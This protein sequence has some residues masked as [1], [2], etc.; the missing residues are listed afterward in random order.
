MNWFTNIKKESPLE[1]S[2]DL[3]QQILED[4]KDKI[5]IIDTPRIT[6]GSISGEVV[7]E[8]SSH[9]YYSYNFDNDCPT[10]LKTFYLSQDEIHH[11]LDIEDIS[12][13]RKSEICMQVPSNSLPA[14]DNISTMILS[15]ISDEKTSLQ[16]ESLANA[17]RDEGDYGIDWDGLATDLHNAVERIFNEYLDVAVR[18]E[19]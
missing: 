18:Y 3:L 4:N 1:R 10:M 9:H 13:D 17:I 16:I 6:N 14:G 2:F 8:G 12:H 19:Q 5:Q 7:I 11:L 15:L